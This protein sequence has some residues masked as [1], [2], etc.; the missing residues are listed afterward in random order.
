MEEIADGVCDF[1]V[2]DFWSVLTEFADTVCEFGC[3]D[4]LKNAPDI[5][6]SSRLP[7]ATSGTLRE[8]PRPKLRLAER[9]IP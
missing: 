9:P 6:D 1:R 5:P 3:P 8:E 2:V 7:P 4:A